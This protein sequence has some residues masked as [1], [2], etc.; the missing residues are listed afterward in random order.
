MREKIDPELKKEWE[1]KLSEL[2]LGE[3]LDHP[4]KVPVKMAETLRM[5]PLIS[6]EIF[7][8]FS[9]LPEKIRDDILDDVKNQHKAGKSFDEISERAITL[10]TKGEE[11]LR[12]D[13]TSSDR[14]Y[15]Q[16]AT[17]EGGKLRKEEGAEIKNSE[18]FI[19]RLEELANSQDEDES[20]KETV[21]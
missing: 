2:G 12:M 14:E 17:F 13:A 18:E 11:L 21:H 6:P 5:E 10:I 9:V 1:D 4:K 15:Q 7:K 8:R 20:P 3:S 16:P 19:Q